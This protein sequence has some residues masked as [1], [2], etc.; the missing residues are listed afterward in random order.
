M[1][2]MHSTEQRNYLSDEDSEIGK[3]WCKS[4]LTPWTEYS[5]G[6]KSGGK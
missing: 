4:E 1:T 6:T 3:I 2:W 5:A